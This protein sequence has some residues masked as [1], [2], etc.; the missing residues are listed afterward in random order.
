MNGTTPLEVLLENVAPM[1]Q[2]RDEQLFAAI[3]SIV[4]RQNSLYKLRIDALNSALRSPTNVLV[5]FRSLGG[6][7][8]AMQA[9][10]YGG[11]V[12]YQRDGEIVMATLSGSGTARFDAKAGKLTLKNA[13]L[14][15][16]NRTPCGRSG[17]VVPVKQEAVKVVRGWNDDRITISSEA[18]EAT[19]LRVFMLSHD[20]MSWYCVQN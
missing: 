17:F 13:D 4:D 9:P 19:D 2:T 12:A 11:F 8:L 6:N 10:P 7:S 3:G 14:L 16:A 5:A 15:D 20:G 18:V 1:V